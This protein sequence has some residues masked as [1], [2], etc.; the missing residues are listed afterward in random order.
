MVEEGLGLSG[1]L[2]D[3]KGLRQ[4]L[5]DHGVVR[6][7]VKAAVEG[8]NRSRSSQTVAGEVELVH[9]MQVLDVELGGG[10][11]G[12]LGHPHVQ[13][14]MLSGLKVQN[15]VAVVHLSNLV[16]LVQLGL[17]VELGLLS[18][19]GKHGLEIADEMSLSE[20]HSSRS[21]DQHSLLVGHSIVLLL[22][23][24]GLRALAAQGLV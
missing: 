2:G 20:G 22:G 8:Q 24:L 11:V 5:L 12:S 10:T 15:V 4:H 6:G 23:L 16:E 13:I 7:V 18:T 19:M 14:H 1:T 9:G 3:T 21:D 17:G